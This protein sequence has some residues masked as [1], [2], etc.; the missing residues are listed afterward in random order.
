VDVLYLVVASQIKAN[1]WTKSELI[2]FSVDGLDPSPK[3]VK[4][5]RRRDL[6]V[7]SSGEWAKKFNC[8]FELQIEYT[9]FDLSRSIKVRS[10]VADLR[11]INKGE[12]DLA[13]LQ[14]DGE[15]LLTKTD[16]KWSISD[17]VP[18]RQSVDWFHKCVVWQAGEDPRVW[19]T[20]ITSPD[21]KEHYRLA[22][23]P[24]W[25]VEGGIVA[26]EIL[27]ARPEHPDNNL[28]GQRETDVP[29]PFVITV[30]ELESGINK[31]RFG[32][33]RKFELDHIRLRVEIQGWHLGEGRYEC[34]DC[35][36]IQ[37]LTADFVLGSK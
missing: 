31:S 20:A 8:G 6:N 30:E 10:K 18:A 28:L 26:I 9:E 34:P 2:C 3:L 25:A 32:A 35:K 12:G 21:G 16:G 15:Y 5:L 13:L 4:S 14:S 7:R 22:L 11:E 37:E 1:N 24:L 33:V 36:K 23:I 19:E 29:Q 27:V 17:Y